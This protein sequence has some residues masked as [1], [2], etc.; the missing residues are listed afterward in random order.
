VLRSAARP[1]PFSVEERV[2]LGLAE[3]LSPAQRLFV[4]TGAVHA[5][6]LFGPSGALEVVREDVGRHNAVDKV[7]GA[8]LLAER[9]PIDD[10]G[11]LVTSRA[12]FE[13]VQKAVMARIGMVVAVGGATS[14]AVD[15]AAAAGVALVAFLR[16]GRFNRYA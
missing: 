5:A 9:V 7:V 8:R 14:L 16:P 11:L 4:E 12:G 10:C 3:R 6:A 13:I 2:L 1:S 15:L